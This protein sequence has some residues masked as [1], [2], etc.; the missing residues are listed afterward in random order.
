MGRIKKIG[1]RH[2][3]AVDEDIFKLLD[4][5]SELQDIAVTQFVRQLVIKHVLPVDNS[6]AKSI[7]ARKT[8]S[9]MKLPEN[10]KINHETGAMYTD[11]V[12]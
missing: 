9:G 8:A 2:L 7:G 12:F 4:D 1:K 3:V 11:D 5:A 10:A 6:K